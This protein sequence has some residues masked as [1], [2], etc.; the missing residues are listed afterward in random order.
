MV[1]HSSIFLPR[2]HMD[3]QYII[4][5][6][7]MLGHGPFSSDGTQNA[8]EEKVEDLSET[9]YVY[10]GTLECKLECGKAQYNEQ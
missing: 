3:S 9:N 2:K 7:I 5:D 8:T 4:I 10:N 6:N 1:N